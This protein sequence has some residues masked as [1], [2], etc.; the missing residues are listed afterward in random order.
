V[1]RPGGLLVLTV[2]SDHFRALLDGV[3]TAPTKEAAEHYARSVD[4]LLAHH[5]YYTADEWR[6]LLATVGVKLTEVRYYISPEAEQLWD[7]LNRRYGIG[8]RSLFGLLAS[9]RLR[10]LGHQPTMAKIIYD[11]LMPKLRPHYDA[12]VSDRGGGL[13]VIGRKLS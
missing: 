3:K 9:P 8:K 7:R 2:P 5:H 6:V 13:L 4:E 1:L 10:L 11:R 12:K